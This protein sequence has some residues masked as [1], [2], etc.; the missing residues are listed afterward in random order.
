MT[1][2]ISRAA[3]LRW[4][5]AAA[6]AAL[7]LMGG[8]TLAIAEDDPSVSPRAVHVTSLGEQ[9]T[10]PGTSRAAIVGI[11]RRHLG[12][13]ASDL[14]LP[15]SLW[16]GDFVNRVRREAGLRPVPSRLARDQVRIG[17]RLSEPRVG[18]IAVIS[19]R[20]GRLAG[21]TG[22]IW[23]FDQH[24]VMLISGNAAGRRVAEETVSRSRLIAII[25]PS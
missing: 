23:G 2:P 6:T 18:A 14:G 25:D 9:A 12:K 13:R 4:T 11:A 3:L 22:I 17:S 8:V 24:H 15:R 16:C 1:D 10:A 20:G 19:R 7:V 5:A 21:H